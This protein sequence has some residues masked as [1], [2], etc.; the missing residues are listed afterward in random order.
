MTETSSKDLIIGSAKH[1]EVF[2]QTGGE[3]YAAKRFEFHLYF[4][5]INDPFLAGVIP[6]VVIPSEVGVSSLNRNSTIQFAN[7]DFSNH[8]QMDAFIFPVELILFPT[9]EELY[10]KKYIND[11]ELI[12][13]YNKVRQIAQYIIEKHK[14]YPFDLHAGNIMYDSQ[15]EQVVLFDLDR[16]IFIKNKDL[17]YTKKIDIHIDEK[18]K[19]LQDKY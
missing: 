7:S 8:A 13:I 19:N 6:Q 18:I 17:D 12:N 14:I 16:W 2:P 1:T 3:N 11:E 9:V 10:Q 4:G 15:T 5:A